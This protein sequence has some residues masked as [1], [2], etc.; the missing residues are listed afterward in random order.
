MRSL[1]TYLL[2]S[3]G[4]R[5]MNLRSNLQQNRIRMSDIHR[6]AVIGNFSGGLKE[7]LRKVLNLSSGQAD[8]LQKDLKRQ[9]TGQAHYKKA[10]QII[11]GII[12]M[13]KEITGN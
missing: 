2:V 8:E 13:F 11:G 7:N 1:I 3:T 5:M 12:K 9:D 10:N 4:L 6:F